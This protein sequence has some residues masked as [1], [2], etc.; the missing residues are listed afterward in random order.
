MSESC[1]VLMDE[2]DT[3]YFF[4]D[5]ASNKS[6]M[7]IAVITLVIKKNWPCQVVPVKIIVFIWSIWKI[8]STLDITENGGTG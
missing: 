1:T 5:L 8:F 3:M 2:S 6:E 7:I 4:K